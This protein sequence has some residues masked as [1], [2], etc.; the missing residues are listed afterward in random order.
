LARGEGEVDVL[1]KCSPNR[2]SFGLFCLSSAVRNQPTPR[3]PSA[4]AS[5][6]FNSRR[7]GQQRAAHQGP[8]T[9]DMSRPTSPAQARPKPSP[10]SPNSTP[11][12]S[13]LSLP[14]ISCHHQI[15]LPQARAPPHRRRCRR[16][17]RSGRPTPSEGMSAAAPAV[18][19][20]RGTLPS[21]LSCR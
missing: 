11:L 1:Q 7:L 2:I 6:D 19:H 15:A 10:K 14:L 18:L 3:S 12:G 16:L 13:L 17:G 8:R 21:A 20:H 4:L 5:S 9:S